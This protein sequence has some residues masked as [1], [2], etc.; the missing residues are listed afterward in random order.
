VP[1][2]RAPSPSSRAYRALQT[3]YTRRDIRTIYCVRFWS[4]YARPTRFPQRS[5]STR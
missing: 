4:T 2:R 5:P 3:R 1:A